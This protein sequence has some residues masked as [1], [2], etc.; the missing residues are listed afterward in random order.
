MLVPAGSGK[1]LCYQLP[2]VLARGVSCASV[3]EQSLPSALTFT[4]TKQGGH[5]F[6]LQA[7]DQLLGFSKWL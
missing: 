1:S 7:R 6:E 4:L 2:A 5:V 3:W